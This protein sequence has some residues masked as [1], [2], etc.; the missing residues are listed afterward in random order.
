M[1]KSKAAVMEKNIIK[2]AVQKKK[3][4]KKKIKKKKK[5]KKKKSSKKFIVQ[6]KHYTR[7]DNKKCLIMMSDIRNKFH[8]N[9]ISSENAANI[10]SQ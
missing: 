6:I 7:I 4:R 5:K 1:E 2:V 8:I 3:K 10:K 9:H